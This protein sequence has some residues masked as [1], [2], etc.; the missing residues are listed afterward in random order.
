MAEALQCSLQG[1]GQ[2]PKSFGME[3]SLRPDYRDLKLAHLIPES[4]NASRSPSGP[5]FDACGPAMLRLDEEFV[6]YLQNHLQISCNLAASS[7]PNSG[8]L[9]S[10]PRASPDR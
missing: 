3:E 7:G 2:F 10:N 5:I 4:L 6:A 9:L 1:L 8:A